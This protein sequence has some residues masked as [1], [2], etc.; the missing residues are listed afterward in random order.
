MN[1]LPK[2]ARLMKDIAIKNKLSESSMVLSESQDFI[3]D[4]RDELVMQYHD[5]WIAVYKKDVVGHHKDLLSLVRELR[6][7]G[8]PLQ[9]IAL[10]MLSREEIPLALQFIL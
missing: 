5:Q 6:A 3:Y 1:E 9:H 8:A 7:S 2:Y 4:H 10:E